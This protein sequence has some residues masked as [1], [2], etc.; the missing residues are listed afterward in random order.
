MSKKWEAERIGSNWLC[1]KEKGMAFR[2][3]APDRNLEQQDIGVLYCKPT[4]AEAEANAKLIAAA[5]EL[6]ERLKQLMDMIFGILDIS[7]RVDVP[8]QV[9]D[10]MQ[11]AYNLLKRLEAICYKD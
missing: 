6:L 1:Q 10:A 4:F 8:T 11:D 3:K 2:I 9:T 5:P 7:M